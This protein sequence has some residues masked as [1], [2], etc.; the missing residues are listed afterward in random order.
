MA[1]E[2][3]KSYT[4]AELI[5]TFQLKSLVKEQSERMKSWL[6]VTDIDLSSGE[7]YIFDRIYNLAV[8]SIRGWSEEDLKM[9]F[10]SWVLPLGYLTDNGR[11]LTYFEKTIFATVEGHFLSTKSDFMVAT[12]IL[13]KPEK[14]YFHFQEYKPHKKPSGD[15]MAQLLEAMLV[16]QHQN[17]NENPIYGCEVMGE[18]WR[19]VILEGKTYCISKAYDCTDKDKLLQIIAILRKFRHILETELLD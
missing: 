16:A 3:A 17:A 8:D 12:G 2:K 13:D 6:N 1:K 9:K 19:F 10:I 14:P 11:F 15:S 4:E 18:M 5:K 7:Q